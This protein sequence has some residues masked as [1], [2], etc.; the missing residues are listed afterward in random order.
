MKVHVRCLRWSCPNWRHGDPLWLTWHSLTCTCVRACHVCVCDLIQVFPEGNYWN[1]CLPTCDRSIPDPTLYSP[2]GL[3]LPA[4]SYPGEVF[5][6][7]SQAFWVW[8][9]LHSPHHTG[10]SEA[11]IDGFTYSRGYWAQ[12]SLGRSRSEK[13]WSLSLSSC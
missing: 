1:T 10:A 9:N 4:C 13:K 12:V 2:C 11:S 7:A 6:D 8:A 3:S 5:S